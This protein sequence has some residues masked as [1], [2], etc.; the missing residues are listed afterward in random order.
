MEQIHLEHWYGQNVHCPF[1]GKVAPGRDTYTGCWHYIY[2]IMNDVLEDYGPRLRG[3]LGLNEDEDPCC[4]DIDIRSKV[5]LET[6]NSVEY[7]IDDPG[8]NVLLICF[9][10]RE[11]ELCSWGKEHESPYEKGTGR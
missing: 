6:S 3:I 5:D 11:Q 2:G 9:S 4:T 10:S 8:G 7:E 1:C